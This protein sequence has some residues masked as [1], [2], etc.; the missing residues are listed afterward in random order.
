MTSNT[1]HGVYA[2]S[3]KDWD[4]IKDKII[5]EADDARKKHIEKL[6]KEAEKEGLG[7]ADAKK[8]VQGQQIANEIKRRL[9]PTKIK[10]IDEDA[11]GFV[12]SEES[13]PKKK[14]AS[15]RD[16]DMLNLDSE[17]DYD[18]FGD[19]LNFGKEQDKNSTNDMKFDNVKILKKTIEKSKNEIK[20]KALTENTLVKEDL[21]RLNKWKK[22][23]E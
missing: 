11:F 15:E 9:I 18:E 5:E 16:E 2:Y 22:E 12:F 17:D 14:Q 10:K 8:A 1:R 20:S 7:A 23:E 3:S 13:S 6:E 19:G 21:E 4:K